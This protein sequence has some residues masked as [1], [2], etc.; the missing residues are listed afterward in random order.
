MVTSGIGRNN[1]SEKALA[2]ST[3]YGFLAE[4]YLRSP[5]EAGFHR[6]LSNDI[7]ASLP[8]MFGETM[9]VRRLT[10][11]IERL[12]SSTNHM[13][14]VIL[15]YHNLFAVPGTRKKHGD[16]TSETTVTVKNPY[17]RVEANFTGASLEFPDQIG[18]ELQFL[19][20][21]CGREAK[22]WK[23]G[24]ESRAVKLLGWEAGFI[25]NHLGPGLP[26]ICSRMNRLARTDFYRGIAAITWD[27]VD[28]DFRVLQNYLQEQEERVD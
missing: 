27:F 12:R 10:Y 28:K 23:T 14:K 22:A 13:K 8:D 5:D 16:G 4:V 15:D 9:N 11:Y 24:L 18:V 1:S 19:G 20:F 21:L 3:F 26:E 6:L 17:A 7:V 25:Q 2:R